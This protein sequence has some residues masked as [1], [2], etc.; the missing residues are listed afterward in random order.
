MEY[1]ETIRDHDRAQEVFLNDPKGKAHG[2]GIVCGASGI[3]PVD[4][5]PKN[6]GDV[7]FRRLVSDIGY[8]VFEDCPQVISPSGGFY[9]WF[10]MPEGLSQKTHALGTH[11]LGAGIDVISPKLGIVAPPTTRK[12]GSYVWRDGIMPDLSRIPPFPEVLFDLM[13][14][15]RKKTQAIVGKLAT[16]VGLPGSRREKERNQTLMRI[17]L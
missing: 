9:C 10:R 11:A 12:D 7:T 17:W 5:D 16:E 8:K 13:K 4:V 14:K 1:G 6:G 15:E 2:I 3:T